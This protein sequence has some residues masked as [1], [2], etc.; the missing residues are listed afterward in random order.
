[1]NDFIAIPESRAIVFDI[2][3]G[4][5][6]HEYLDMIVPEFSPPSNFK[7]PDKIAAN[8]AEQKAKWIERAALSPITGKVLCI[9]VRDVDG[10]FYTID[11]DGD[12]AVLLQQW[13]KLSER[14]HTET[15]VG[16]NTSSFDIPF[17]VRRAWKLGVA[18][19]L[20]AGTNLR[21]LENWI[22]LRETWG[23]GDKWTDGSL[24]DVARF[25]GAGSKTGDGKDFASLWTTDK[26]AAIAYLRNDISI[27][28]EVAKRIGVIA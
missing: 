2:E 28:F 1:M 26:D 24:N 23:F 8:L 9:G 22:D 3:T 7:D 12:E 21:Y 17:L 27:T 4:P 16:W 18:P 13:K 5:L 25:L 11:G 19:C 6:P 15:L 10:S 20:R 14:S